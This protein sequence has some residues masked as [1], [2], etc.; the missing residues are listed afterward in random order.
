MPR[1]GVD[2]ESEMPGLG[3][4]EFVEEDE[5][6]WDR[7]SREGRSVMAAVKNRNLVYGILIRVSHHELCF[8]LHDSSMV[9]E[10]D[11]RRVLSMH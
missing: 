2:L 4:A 9:G 1:E 11:H 5:G 7:G 6:D 10:H 3:C 8:C